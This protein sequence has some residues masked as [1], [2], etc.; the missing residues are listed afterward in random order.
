M[1]PP[2]DLSSTEIRLHNQLCLVSYV[3]HDVLCN[4]TNVSFGV[5][6]RELLV[7]F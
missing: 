2:T 1:F 6:N 3:S 7:I 4:H 5:N